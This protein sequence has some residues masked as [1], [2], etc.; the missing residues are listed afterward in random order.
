MEVV[1]D[2]KH[3]YIHNNIYKQY[4]HVLFSLILNFHIIY[5]YLF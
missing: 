3:A 5:I 1:L 2:V 4:M